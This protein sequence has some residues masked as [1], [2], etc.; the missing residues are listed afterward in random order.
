MKT[1]KRRRLLRVAMCVVLV[2][3]MLAESATAA[4]LSAQPQGQ[5]EAD[6]QAESA[7]RPP[8]APSAVSV[9]RDDGTL[10]ASWSA[11][12][13]ATSYHITYSSDGGTTWSL[14]ALKHPDT[15]ITITGADNDATYVVGV[16]ARNAG[17]DSGWVNSSPAGPYEPPSKP[18]PPPPT[19]TQPP[20]PKPPAA[21]AAVSVTRDDGTLTASWPAVEGA[22]SY[23]ITYSSDDGTSWS[24]A[25]LNHA[26]TTIT[27]TGADNDATYVVGVRA[28]NAGG[29]SGWV[30]SA[31]AG[32]HDPGADY[33]SDD[34]GHI[35]VTTLAQLDAI[36]YDLDG[37]G[38]ASTGNES[39]YTAAFPN[40]AQAMGCPQS[41]CTGY[42]LRAD[43]DFDTN[44]NGF[45]DEGDAYWNNGDGWPPITGFDAD[46]DGNNDTDPDGD[47]GPY[48]VYNV[49]GG[50]VFGAA[51]GIG[52]GQPPQQVFGGLGENADV[53]NLTQTGALSE[54]GARAEADAQLID[55][56][57]LTK[58]IAMQWDLN[59]DGTP[60]SQA[61]KYQTAF[62]GS[63]PTC[64]GGCTG[65]ELTADLTITANPTDAGT[66]YLLPGIW[67]TTFSGDGYTIT[68]E[69][70]RPLFETIGTATGSSTAEVKNLKIKNTHASG[71]R[72]GILANKVDD[73]GTVTEVSVQ[74]KVSD[75][76]TLVALGTNRRG[77]MVD[78]LSGGS[79]VGSSA[80]VDM[81]ITIPN[82]SAIPANWI[83]TV[84][85]LVADA[86]TGSEILASYAVGSVSA[87]A[88]T[89]ISVSRSGSGNGYIFDQ[90]GDLFTGG[91]VGRNSGTI[92]AAY[93]RVDVTASENFSNP[94]AVDFQAGGLVGQNGGTVR[95]AYATG[96]VS[97]APNSYVNRDP[98]EN[99]YGSA[100]GASSGTVNDVYGSGTVSYSGSAQ[101][102]SGTST[103]SE[104]ELTTPTGYTGI[105]ANWNLDFDNDDNDNDVTTGGDDQW[106][107]GTASQFP[108]LKYGTPNETPAQQ[109]PASFTL[110]ASNTTIYESAIVV[111]GT[112]RA[113]SSTVTATLTAAKTYDITITLPGNAAYT[114][115]APS[116]TISAGST[117]GT[118]TLDAV[119][120]TKC[121]TGVCGVTAPAN[122]TQALTPTATQG[123]RLS[124]TAPTLTITD[125]DLF[126]KPTGVSVAGKTSPSTELDV[127]W[128]AITAADAGNTAPDGYYVDWK[129]GAED[130]DTI[131]RRNTVTSG[132]TS[133]ITG[134][135]ANTTYT[136]RVIAYKANYENSPAS[137]EDTGTPGKIDYDADNDDLIE[138][139]SLAQFNAI[140]HDLDGDGSSTDAAYST[141]FPNADTG[142]G[143]PGGSCDGY[144][145]RANLDFN[146]DGSTPTATNPTGASSGDTYWNSGAGWNP[147]GGST[148]YSAHFDGNSDTDTG[149]D[150]GPYTIKNLFIDRT[151]GNYAGLFG[152]LSLHV[153]E[154]IS[155]VAL[156]NVDVTLNP[157]TSS[158][159]YVGGLAGYL[160]SAAIGIKDS[161]TTGR[162]RAGESASDPITFT[163]ASKATYVGGLLGLLESGAHRGQLL[164]R[165]RDEPRHEFFGQ[166]ASQ[167][168]RSG[169][170]H[171]RHFRHRRPVCGS[172]LRR[173]CGHG[174][175]RDHIQQPLCLCGRTDR[176]LYRLGRSEGQLCPGRCFGNHLQ[177]GVRLGRGSAGV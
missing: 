102:P 20:A 48:A 173:R 87:L 137:D 84:G 9:A 123:A 1:P 170:W 175:Q 166:P 133:T 168:G 63:N 64:T 144:E 40:A 157:S 78:E 56:D 94:Q 106:N 169:R 68:N 104:S 66:S 103:K 28:R 90:S 126:G 129:S 11:V 149:G 62:G 145:L 172:E 143:C 124:G 114:P 119:N 51:E 83:V 55:V 122:V 141:A 30:N 167:S 21:P 65:Y 2:F 120:N 121:G 82:D 88:E 146:T 25:A 97:D 100:M 150:G 140:R 116:I 70:R 3:P 158:D 47:G 45:A 31:P 89:R 101:S 130:Y 107:F 52:T 16:R 35:E 38:T 108:T 147:I 7:S 18:K 44:G 75:T 142:M 136:V 139:S 22:T 95:A 127:S 79:I 165:R 110:S 105:Y 80:H 12:A 93:A 164:P 57:S 177:Y 67:N 163:A 92:Y 117:S 42:E 39:A 27:V 151:S 152:N 128:D 46:F 111:S 5:S 77:G 161:Y 23:H 138:V 96:N 17:G 36:R 134:L 155:N 162:V 86:G 10:T 59:G 171:L 58:F 32:P 53:Y 135:T 15:T 91:L 115:A 98:H 113:T 19:P 34:D 154:T 49:Y 69:D 99:E 24:L 174:Q 85:G 131:N 50:S 153:R 118:V 160:A 4:A 176:G 125:D 73:N 61:S 109:Q 156:E 76:L 54:D 43:L 112:A 74:G 60:E 13:R 26:D 132:T 81:D 6:A 159:V 29:D 33:D 148:G 14:A 37:D 41:G 8:A 72:S 71:T